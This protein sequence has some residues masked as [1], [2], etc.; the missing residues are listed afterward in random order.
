MLSCASDALFTKL[1]NALGHAQWYADP[2]F[3]TN[4]ARLRH[5]AQL[6]ALLEACLREHPQEYW[7]RRLRAG[8]VPCAPV[9]EVEEVLRY[10]QVKALGI[11]GQPSNEEFEV[12]GLPLSFDGLRPPPPGAAG[13]LGQDNGLQ[14][15]LATTAE[16]R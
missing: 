1:Y 10:E 11:L 3:T 8:G 2:R 4:N 5:R 7:Q 13:D 9:Q 12:V 16:S 14:P 15:T 6:D